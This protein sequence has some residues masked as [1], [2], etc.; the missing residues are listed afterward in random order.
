MTERQTTNKFQVAVA[1]MNGWRNSMED[2]HV[3]DMR[4]EYGVFGVFDGHGGEACS[5]FVAKRMH[6]EL[7]KNG[8]PADDAAAKKLFLDIDKEFLDSE[9]QSGSTATMCV[10]RKPRAAGEKHKLHVINAG[11]SRVLLGRRDG[12]IVDGNGTDQGLTKDHKPDDPEERKRIERCG[13]RV[14]H[15]EGNCAR[16]N[17]NLAVSRGFG[18]KEEKKTGGPD[19]EDRPVT[20]DPEMGH[21]ECDEADFLLLVCDGV[22]EGNFPNPEVVRL[23]ADMLRDGKDI[24]AAAEAVCHKAVETDSKDNITCMIVL[25]SGAETPAAKTVEF[26]S[27]PI[28]NFGHKGFRTAYTAMAEKAGL[29]LAEAAANRHAALELDLAAA[30]T[31]E[32]RQEAAFI[33]KPAGDFG[34]AER[35][36]WFEN[37]IAGIPEEKETGPGGMDMDSIQQMMGGK[38][39]GKGGGGGGGKGKDKGYAPDA[40]EEVDSGEKDENGYTW[41]EKGEEVQITFKL[42]TVAAKRDVKVKFSSAALTVD[43]HG[44]SLLDGSLGGKVDTDECTWCVAN[45]GKELQVMLTK[46]NAKDVWSKLLK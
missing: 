14:E 46:K 20:A 19:P 43:V 32:L 12:T 4:D 34:S 7:E 29:T 37:W 25:L 11:D 27:G 26:T 22:S 44:S 5:A 39:G 6:E 16:V 10:V 3:I 33:G 8:C 9:Q 15:A 40:P 1:E 23:V 17:G 45:G 31:E 41:S 28:V 18:D 2:A 24:G 13:G 21:F 30:P 42:P 38:G 36:K 35:T